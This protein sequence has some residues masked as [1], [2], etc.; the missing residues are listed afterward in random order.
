[1]LAW[2]PGIDET[3]A[4]SDYS[5][6]LWLDETGEMGIMTFNSCGP[7]RSFSGFTL[8]LKGGG[9]EPKF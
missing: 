7:V 2:L 6:H 5:G 3:I 4:G 9:C 1:M 8:F